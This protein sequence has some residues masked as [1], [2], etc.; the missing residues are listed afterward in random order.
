M[1]G[2]RLGLEMEMVVADA[3]TGLSASVNSY[4][5]ALAQLKSDRNVAS[6]PIFLRGR[7]IGLRTEDAECGLDNGF[8]LLETALA[9]VSGDLGGLDRLA[10]LA[11]QEVFDT[12][13][14]LSQDGLTVLNSA[15]HP[16][17]SRDQRFYEQVRVPRPIY[18]ELVHHRGWAHHEGIDAKAQ[19]GANTAVPVNQIA[20]ALNV[21][22]G[23]TAATIAIF[24]NSPLEAGQVTGLKETRMTLWSRM[25]KSARFGGDFE[26]QRFPSH[27]FRDL[28]DYFHLLFGAG[29]ASRSLPLGNGGDYKAAATAVLDGDPCLSDFLLSAG[30]SARRLDDGS[31]LTLQPCASHFVHSQIAVFFD[32][33][34]RYQLQQ[35]PSL[36]RLL[37]AWRQDGGLESLFDTCG[38]DG[39]I[40][41]RAAGANF[42]DK[43]LVAEAGTT[44]AHSV[45]MGPSA[46]QLGLLNNMPEALLL[47]KD[48]GWAKLG[49]MRDAAIRQ[50]LDDTRVRALCMDVLSVAHRGLS[51]HDQKWLNY[52]DYVVASG[53]SGADRLLDTWGSGKAKTPE[54]RLVRVLDQHAATLPNNLT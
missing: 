16:A 36:E 25:F 54:A 13:R 30:W 24:A 21:V 4:F 48:W 50:G 53:R 42:A 39:Y 37:A 31:M 43:R 17:C 46:L 47:I 45:L 35:M 44:V 29:T 14:G 33:R 22:I 32:A 9:P 49:S 11:H 34:F 26:L 23:L 12:L 6:E 15:Q 18:H 2:S 7:C 40:E 3:R 38:I 19:N 28:A 5:T 1:V 20:Q 41:G 27:P 51:A 52:V 8:N 10:E